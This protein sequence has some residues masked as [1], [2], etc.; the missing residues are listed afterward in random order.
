MVWI[1]FRH[2]TLEAE[3]A[4]DDA[5]LGLSEATAYAD[6]LVGL[7]RRLSLTAKSP[8]LA[9]ANRADLATRVRAVLD[10]RQQRGRAG[11]FAVALA[12]AASIA[13]IIAVSPLRMVAAPQQFDAVSVKLI[14]PNMQGSHSHE[15]SDPKRISM[16]STMHRFVLRA[17]GLTAPQLIGEPEWF[18]T[19][20][21]SV[22]AV[23]STPASDDQMLLMLRTAL[24]DRFQLKLRQEDRNLPI[25][26][27]EVAPG[28]PKFKALNPGE[29]PQDGAD[30]PGTFARSFTD[31]KDLMNVLNGV[32]GGRLD[33]DRPVIDRTHLTGQYNI[34]LRTD[35]QTIK[36]DFG[37]RVSLFPNL[38]QDIQRELGLKLVPDHLKM[39]C[40]VVEHAAEPTAN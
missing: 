33:L 16:T 4:C 22:E 8:L 9:M 23:T 7:A 19:H 20:L 10:G 35:V 26:S 18:R 11:A 39:P 5:V 14:D 21:Y 31:M 34:Q 17:Y 3:R 36:D 13:L 24:A 28:G 32:N 27:L 12:C 30:I 37:Q 6:Q 25:Y 40:F 15:R 29:V 38:L 2:L 1:A